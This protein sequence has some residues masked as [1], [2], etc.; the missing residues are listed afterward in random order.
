MDAHPYAEYFNLT[1]FFLDETF[2]QLIADLKV[3]AT[4]HFKFYNFSWHTKCSALI[5]IDSFLLLGLNYQLI[6]F[7][8]P[9][10]TRKHH[11]TKTQPLRFEASLLR[12]TSLFREYYLEEWCYLLQGFAFLFYTIM[13]HYYLLNI[14]IFIIFN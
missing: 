6:F 5:S 10:I 13:L 3:K 12:V 11:I 1:I 14:I 7:R 4:L 2:I 8:H 9:T